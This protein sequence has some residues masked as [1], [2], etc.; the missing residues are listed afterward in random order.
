M[1]GALYSAAGDA[2]M[3]ADA[4]AVVP[5]IDDEVVALRLQA[6]G[7]VDGGAEQIIV[8]GGPERFA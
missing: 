7:A 3:A 1:R 6:D 4:R 5:V 2:H 8:G